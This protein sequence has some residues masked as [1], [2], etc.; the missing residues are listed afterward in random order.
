MYTLG[1]GVV[2][3]R[4]GEPSISAVLLVSGELQGQLDEEK[5]QKPVIETI[6]VGHLVGEYGLITGKHILYNVILQYC[7]YI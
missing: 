3:W 2:I 6:S 1:Q 4:Q 7:Y 5:G